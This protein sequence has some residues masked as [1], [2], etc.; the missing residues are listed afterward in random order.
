MTFL[1][2]A[3]S[4]LFMS[5][6]SSSSTSCLVD[7]DAHV[8]HIDIGYFSLKLIVNTTGNNGNNEIAAIQFVGCFKRFHVGKMA[9]LHGS[10]S[11]IELTDKPH[12]KKQRQQWESRKFECQQFWTTF[13]IE[14]QSFLRYRKKRRALEA[15]KRKQRRVE[16]SCHPWCNLFP[17]SFIMYRSMTLEMFHFSSI[18]FSIFLWFESCR[19]FES[20]QSFFTLS[21][22]MSCS[23]RAE[24]RKLTKVGCGDGWGAEWLTKKS[25]ISFRRYWT[26]LF[27]F[28]TFELKMSKCV[29]K[30][31]GNSSLISLYYVSF[32]RMW[33]LERWAMFRVIF[34]W[35]LSIFLSDTTNCWC[36]NR[37]VDRRVDR[38]NFWKFLNFWL[39]LVFV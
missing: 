36:C 18:H 38:G 25:K 28:C 24:I 12:T 30:C 31:K 19:V 23:P 13:L 8:T 7:L 1:P 2:F 29:T 33:A 32:T 14:F 15:H 16:S 22:S 5:F 34:S 37:S 27:Y 4:R 6:S 11:W 20:F 10:R 9:E 3:C 35:K 26:S 17:S 21:S 39:I